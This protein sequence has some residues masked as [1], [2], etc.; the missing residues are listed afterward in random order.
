MPDSLSG[1]CSAFGRCEEPYGIFHTDAAPV[2][3]FSPDPG[4]PMTFTVPCALSARFPACWRNSF[5]TTSTRGVAQKK[6][7]RSR[8]AWGD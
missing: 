2:A 6:I 5:L 8:E 4:P 7:A 1:L 3:G